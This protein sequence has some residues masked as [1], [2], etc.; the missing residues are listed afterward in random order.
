[1]HTRHTMIKAPANDPERKARIEKR[2]EPWIRRELQAITGDSD[3]SILVHL[4]LSLWFNAITHR[5]NNGVIY[6]S[7]EQWHNRTPATD[8]AVFGDAEAVGQLYP[9]L[10]EKASAFWHEL[11]CFAESPYSLRAYDS[12]TKYEKVRE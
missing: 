5:E 1:M 9:F 11:K 12:V 10:E 6:G 7:S 2:L 4:V 8:H 3:T